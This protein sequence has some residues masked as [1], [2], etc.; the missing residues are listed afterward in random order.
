MILETNRK[1]TCF[2]HRVCPG[3]YRL[4]DIEV[5]QIWHTNGPCKGSHMWHVFIDGKSI[6]S[7]AYLKDAKKEAH[8]IDRK[9][10]QSQ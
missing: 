3:L 8:R 4:G 10:N 6:V 9:C 7:H 1:K 2:W 5:E